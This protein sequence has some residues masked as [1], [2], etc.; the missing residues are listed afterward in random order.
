M[1]CRAWYEPVEGGYALSTPGEADRMVQRQCQRT[2]CHAS[3]SSIMVQTSHPRGNEP[4]LACGARGAAISPGRMLCQAEPEQ[5]WP[6]IPAMV[7]ASEIDQ[8]VYVG[9]YA[10]MFAYRPRWC[11]GWKVPVT[12]RKSPA[13][14]ARSGLQ[15]RNAAVPGEFNARGMDR[16]MKKS[17]SNRSLGSAALVRLNSGRTKQSPGPVY[18]VCLAGYNTGRYGELRQR[19]VHEAGVQEVNLVTVPERKGSLA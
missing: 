7:A 3:R 5:Q 17:P 1:S 14:T 4:G 19:S 10:P 2:G 16:L 18:R 6:G 12:G 13:G 11:R 15:P 9:P 8:R